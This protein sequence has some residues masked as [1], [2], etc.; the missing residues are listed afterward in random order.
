MGLCFR[1]GAGWFSVYDARL[2]KDAGA[3]LRLT[4]NI[5][6]FLEKVVVR[7]DVAQA[8]NDSAEDTHFWFGV[9]HAF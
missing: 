7:V 2:R 6:S 1:R 4:V 3:G 9:N 8:I 5:G